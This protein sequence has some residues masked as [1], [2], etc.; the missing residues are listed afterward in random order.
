MPDAGKRAFLYL[1]LIGFYIAWVL[2][3]HQA[4][5]CGIALTHILAY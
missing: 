5:A 3:L 1:D 4:C 2:C